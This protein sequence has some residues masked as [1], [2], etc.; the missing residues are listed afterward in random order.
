MVMT[1]MTYAHRD[2][3][4]YLSYPSALTLTTLWSNMASLACKQSLNTEYLKYH[5]I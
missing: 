4:S 5:R 3:D 2:T 1:V